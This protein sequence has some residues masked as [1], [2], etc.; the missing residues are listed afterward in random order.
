MARRKASGMRT[1]RK[2]THRAKSPDN[3]APSRRR[4]VYKRRRKRGAG[5]LY[6]KPTYGRDPGLSRRETHSHVPALRPS[7]CSLQVKRF[8]CD[9]QLFEEAL[10]ASIGWVAGPSVRES[11]MPPGTFLSWIRAFLDLCSPTTLRAWAGGKSSESSPGAAGVHW[12][13]RLP[14]PWL[15]YAF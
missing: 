13:R 12:A 15:C 11:E 8:L 4:F 3:S 6:I 10:G 1:T 14:P 5:A 9:S 2:R 7:K